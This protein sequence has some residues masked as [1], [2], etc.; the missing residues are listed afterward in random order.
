VRE[1]ADSEYGLREFVVR[2]VYGFRV[3]FATPI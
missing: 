1:I 3:R 2:D